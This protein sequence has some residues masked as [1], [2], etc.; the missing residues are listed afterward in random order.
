MA[1][2]REF[3]LAEARVAFATVEAAWR[4]VRSSEVGQ[5]RRDFDEMS[6]QQDRLR[7]AGK[8]IGGACDLLSIIGRGR[9]ETYHSAI[10]A[11]L[12]NPS[13]RH[14]LGTSFLRALL[15][16]AQVPGGIA[17]DGLVAAVPAIEVEGGTSRADIIVRSPGLHVVI[18]VKVD[19]REGDEQLQ[20]L[21]NDH[22][23][24]SASFIFL[25]PRGRPP[26][27]CEPGIAELWARLSFRTVKAALEQVL[28]DRTHLAAESSHD[29]SG[30][31]NYLLTLKKE[32]P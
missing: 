13:G 22:A 24:P 28:A 21:Y 19:A 6:V 18:E 15:V 10:L 8:W 26:S 11:W 29:S 3:D 32:F 17:D 7:A 4:S 30:A 14:G 25:T 27:S 5:W 12:L 31:I 23:S 20:R 1:R 9:R 2:S 16:E